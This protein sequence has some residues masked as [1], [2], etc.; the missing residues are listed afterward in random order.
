MRRFI[1]ICAV[2]LFVGCGG[3]RPGDLLE[4]RHRTAIYFDEA[5]FRT[6]AQLDRAK[7]VRK[8]TYDE[9]YRA[10]KWDQLNPRAVIRVLDRTPDGLKVVVERNIRDNEWAANL[11]GK[12]GWILES[13]VSRD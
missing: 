9:N 11:E 2:C 1:P 13:D 4:I 6:V 12:I 5:I 3:P 7:S 10:R 8:T